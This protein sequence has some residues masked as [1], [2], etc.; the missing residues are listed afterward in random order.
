MSISPVPPSPRNVSV[1]RINGTTIRVQWRPITLIEARGLITKYLI[2]Y[3]KDTRRDKRDDDEQT[4]EVDAS[5][6]HDYIRGL[7]EDFGYTVTV[8]AFTSQGGGEPSDSVD[9]PANTTATDDGGTV[10]V[11][12]T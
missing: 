8:S 2:T 1:K 4:K 5:M 12:T 11:I 9:V 6:D 7:D 10:C 3:T